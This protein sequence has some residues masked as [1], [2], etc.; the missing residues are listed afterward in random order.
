MCVKKIIIRAIGAKARWSLKL[1]PGDDYL[2][3]TIE[4]IE[5]VG[6]VNI[7]EVVIILNNIAKWIITAAII[8]GEVDGMMTTEMSTTITISVVNYE[9]HSK[10]TIII[11][12]SFSRIIRAL[13]NRT[14]HWRGTTITTITMNT[15]TIQKTL[16]TLKN[17]NSKRIIVGMRAR[18]EA[19]AH[20]KHR[21]NASTVI[22]GVAVGD[23]L[24][25][26]AEVAKVW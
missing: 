3:I 1:I 14:R 11:K 10:V 5:V 24:R 6:V 21:M 12:A 23:Y 26:A 19:K 4:K 9:W 2:K 25:S 18:R 7:E 22:E 17:I 15:T 20:L 16:S 8:V 13:W